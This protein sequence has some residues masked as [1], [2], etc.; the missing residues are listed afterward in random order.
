[1]DLVVTMIHMRNRLP[2]F[3]QDKFLDKIEKTKIALEV[4]V[5]TLLVQI[6]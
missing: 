2:M 6:K 5:K 3:M 1:M 4:E